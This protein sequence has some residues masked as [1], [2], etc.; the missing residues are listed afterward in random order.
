MYASGNEIDIVTR[1]LKQRQRRQQRQQRKTI[2]LLS[3]N[4]RSALAFYI[5]VHFFAVLCKR[6][7]RNEN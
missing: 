5:L 6:T 3:K 7:T 1:E 4:N 2:G